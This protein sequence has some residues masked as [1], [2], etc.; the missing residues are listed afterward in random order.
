M[1][2]GT[3]KSSRFLVKAAQ[4]CHNDPTA[5]LYCFDTKGISFNNVKGIPGVFVFDD[6]FT[7]EGKQEIWQ[8]WYGLEK[9][10][11]KRYEKVRAG[12]RKLSDYNNVWVLMDE[13]NDLAGWLLNIWHGMGQNNNSPAVWREAIEPLCRV[14]RQCGI[15]G[16]FMLQDV[17]D[18][19]LGGVSLKSAFSKFT[20]AGYLPTSFQRTIGSPAP[21]LQTGQ[22]RAL[23]IRGREQEWIQCFYDDPEWLRAYALKNRKN[24]AA[25]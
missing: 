17:T 20:M 18:K 8:G 3:G 19:A 22:G 7:P 10:L 9:I 15:R 14:G 6:P 16:E 2:S 1:N 5:D 24:R 13:G 12:D 11:R 4:I 23:M 21:P 25:A